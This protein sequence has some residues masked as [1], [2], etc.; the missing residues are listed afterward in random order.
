C[1]SWLP[2]GKNAPAQP[3]VKTEITHEI[4]LVAG[5]GAAVARRPTGGAAGNSAA[6]GPVP[7]QP[8]F[9]R[10]VRHRRFFVAPPQKFG[11]PVLVAGHGRRHRPPAPCPRTK[12]TARHFWRLRRGRRH[13]HG[14]ADGGVASAGLAGGFLSS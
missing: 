9:Q 2:N 6:A 7:A 5:S 1:P 3:S 12:R 11:R 8:R 13:F 10:A 4:S 14:A